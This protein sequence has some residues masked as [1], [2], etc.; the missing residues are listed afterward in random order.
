MEGKCSGCGVMF[1]AAQWFPT[2]CGRCGT[3][4][5]ASPID[6]ANEDDAGETKD[7]DGNWGPEDGSQAH[8]RR[9]RC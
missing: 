6:D 3:R 5:R 1:D 7:E 9:A 4:L 2:W 8:R